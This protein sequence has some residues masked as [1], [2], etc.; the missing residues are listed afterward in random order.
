[1]IIQYSAFPIITSGN[2]PF[3]D[4]VIIDTSQRILT[5]MKRSLNIIGYTSRTIKFRDITEVQLIHRRELF[6]FSRINIITLGGS[7]ISISGLKPDEAK[8]VK[9]IIDNMR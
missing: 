2:F 8:D 1:M 7:V 6:I 5:Y 4:K 9:Y 3:R